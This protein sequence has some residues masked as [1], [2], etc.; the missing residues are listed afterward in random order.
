MK[1]RLLQSVCVLAMVSIWVGCNG[2]KPEAASKDV[3]KSGDKTVLVSKLQQADQLDGKEDHVIGKCYVCGL[4]MDGK[5]DHSAEFEG[6]TAHLCSDMCCKHFKENAE[7]VITETDVPK[8]A[9][10]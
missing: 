3:P 7:K 6:Y 5:A 2:P 9:E 4:G 8:T 1:I 10:K